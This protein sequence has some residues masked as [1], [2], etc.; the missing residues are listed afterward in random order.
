M[1]KIQP[2]L[3][4]DRIK[5][6]LPYNSYSIDNYKKFA[7]IDDSIIENKSE[8]IECLNDNPI[9]LDNSLSKDINEE[10]NELNDS[11]NL[12]DEILDKKF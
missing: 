8:I 12:N 4:F 1:T 9:I 3:A 7:D 10:G 2:N 6:L 11:Y 5:I